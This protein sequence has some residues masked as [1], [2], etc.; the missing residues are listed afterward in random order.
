MF[1]VYYKKHVYVKGQLQREKYVCGKV[2]K[3]F[4]KMKSQ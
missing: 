4:K 1:A 3:N 2:E